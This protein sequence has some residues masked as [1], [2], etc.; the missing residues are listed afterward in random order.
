MGAEAGLYNA[1]VALLSA[2][3][4]AMVLRRAAEELARASN[5]DKAA[6]LLGGTEGLLTAAVVGADKVEVPRSLVRG[7]LERKEAGRAKGVLCAPLV[8]SGGAPFGILYAERPETLRRG[9]AADHRGAGTAGR[10]GGDGA[11]RAR[12]TSA[13]GTV[14]AGGHQPAVPQDGG[15]GA[16]R[17]GERRSRGASSASPAPGA[18]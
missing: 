15:A 17:G 8:A 2:T 1:G 9:G 16:A 11:A 5:A 10:R 3:S 13:G 18:R 4:E 6:A 7:A 14:V 12:P